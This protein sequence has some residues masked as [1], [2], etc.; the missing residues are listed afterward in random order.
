MNVIG[1]LRS[2]VGKTWLCFENTA[3]PVQ[4]AS[5]RWARGL[6]LC[7]GLNSL[8]LTAAVLK[9]LPYWRAG[10]RFLINSSM[11]WYARLVCVF[12]SQ[13]L[14]QSMVKHNY[15]YDSYCFDSVSYCDS[16]VSHFTVMPRCTVQ[17]SACL[18]VC[19]INS[20][21]YFSVTKMYLF[22]ELL[23]FVVN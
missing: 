11:A 6:C 7:I 12:L 1:S 17:L 3:S 20:P 10:L 18:A 13:V 14:G 21:C 23:Q 22:L 5:V 2:Q 8:L 16:R 4:V 19:W 15:V 9:C